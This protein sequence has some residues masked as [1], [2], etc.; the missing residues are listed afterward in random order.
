MKIKIGS[1]L[2]QWLSNKYVWGGMILTVLLVLY[3]FNP[4]E[5]VLMPK[6]AFKLMTGYSCPGCGFLRATH[7]A[8]HGHWAE[9]W[10]YNR[11][12]IYSIPY[13]VCLVI[14]QFVLR[15]EW[16]RKWRN[17]FES[18]TARYIYIAVFFVWWVVRNVKGI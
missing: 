10:A 1:F 3:W 18:R 17:V 6:C 16:Q 5:H 14:G 2:T 12:L 7:A 11:M 8:L 13:A 15:G 4:V 9:A